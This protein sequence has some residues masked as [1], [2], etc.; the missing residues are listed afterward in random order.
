MLLDNCSVF[1][2]IDLAI[3]G[4]WYMNRLVHLIKIY[5]C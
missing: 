3:P 1:S 2:L 5:I 4:S